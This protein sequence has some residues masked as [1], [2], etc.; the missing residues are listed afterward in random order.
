MKLL[1]VTPEGLAVEGGRMHRV[2]CHLHGRGMLERFVVD[3]AHCVSSWG[4]DFRCRTFPLHSVL[5]SRPPSNVSF[6]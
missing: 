4:H 6:S 3:E 2:L 1:Y 5:V